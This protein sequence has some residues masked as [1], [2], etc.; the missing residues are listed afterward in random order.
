MPKVQSALDHPG[1]ALI[2]VMLD[3]KQEFEPRIKSKQL[4]DGKIVTPALEDMYPFLDPE[5]LASNI[6]KD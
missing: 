1:P 2:E 4:P 5:E 3:P 6:I